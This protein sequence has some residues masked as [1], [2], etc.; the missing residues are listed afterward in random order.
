M[1]VINNLMSAFNFGSFAYW[2]CDRRS[3]GG[4]HHQLAEGEVRGVASPVSRASGEA[5]V[6]GRA[7][8]RTQVA[9]SGRLSRFHGD[10][11]HPLRIRSEFHPRHCRTGRWGSRTAA[12]PGGAASVG[13][14]RSWTRCFG[15]SSGGH[16]RTD[17]HR[18]PH[19]RQGKHFF[20][21]SKL[22]STWIS[23]ESHIP[24][25]TKMTTFHRT[26]AQIVVCVT[27][28]IGC[29]RSFE[30]ATVAHRCPTVRAWTRASTWSTYWPFWRTNWPP[31][32][33]TWRASK[34]N[35]PIRTPTTR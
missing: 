4:L 7:A 9:A 10:T 8:W 30:C 3:F 14:A 35:I 2:R 24:L 20:F 29:G 32:P 28:E 1:Q 11:I 31:W 26:M 12:D 23:S 5:E 27:R 13:S 17:R 6:H 34:P 21:F 15:S 33:N 18:H 22:K 25:W 19:L 16:Q